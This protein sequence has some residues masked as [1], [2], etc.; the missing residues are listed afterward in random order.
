MNIIFY[1]F[2]EC[3]YGNQYEAFCST[4]IVYPDVAKY[5]NLYEQGCCDVCFHYKNTSYPGKYKTQLL[6]QFFHTSVKTYRALYFK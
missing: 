2:I 4:N 5:C 1:P 3:Y 6:S